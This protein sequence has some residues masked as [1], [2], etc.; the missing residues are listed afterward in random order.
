MKKTRV[1]VEPNDTRISILNFG[2]V[3]LLK[4]ISI[5]KNAAKA[6]KSRKKRSTTGSVRATASRAIT[7]INDHSKT[8]PKSATKAFVFTFI[9]TKFVNSS[10]IPKLHLCKR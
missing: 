1:T 2:L 3:Q 8:V 10:T 4:R 6:T 7:T 9:D 5:G